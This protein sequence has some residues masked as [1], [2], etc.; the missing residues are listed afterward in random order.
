VVRTGRR[1]STTFPDGTRAYGQRPAWR[2]RDRSG[3]ELTGAASG[4]KSSS[5][6]DV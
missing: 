6:S 2:S 5:A 1:G 4:S 3:L